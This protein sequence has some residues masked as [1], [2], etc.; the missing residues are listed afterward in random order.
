MASRWQ[1]LGLAAIAGPI[2]FLS[3]TLGSGLLGASCT[4][5][6]TAE[7]RVT[8]A[9]RMVADDAVE[10]SIVNAYGWSLQLTRIALST[11]PLY[12][13]NGSPAVARATPSDPLR[14]LRIAS[15][16]AHPGHYVPGDAMGKCCNQHRSTSRSVRPPYRRVKA[17]RE[18]TARRV[19]RFQ[20]RPLE[21]PQKPLMDTSSC[22]KEQERRAQ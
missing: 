17:F 1:R 6:T 7:K 11:G 8:L 15:A 14:F 5:E 9:T 3:S 16:Y 22:L 20:K 19:L 2:F 12:Y 21:T 10:T 4:N 13:W 18:Y